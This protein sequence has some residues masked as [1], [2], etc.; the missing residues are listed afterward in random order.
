MSPDE[1]SPGLCGFLNVIVHSASG[2]QHSLSESTC[3]SIGAQPW[4]RLRPPAVAMAAL[5]NAEVAIL[6]YLLILCK[7]YKYLC[8]ETSGCECVAAGSEVRGRRFLLT[9]GSPSDL[10]CTLE[11]DSFGFFSNKA[12]TRV[13]RYTSEPK[14]NEVSP[15]PSPAT[16]RDSLL[17]C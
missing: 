11:V 5:I 9:L 8:C 4:Q 14:W 6:S 13:Y 17:A 10:Y 2:L 12:K 16:T 1:D 7:L 15:D 3:W